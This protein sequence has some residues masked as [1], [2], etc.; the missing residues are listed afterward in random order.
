WTSARTGADGTATV[1]SS[2]VKTGSFAARMSAT[3]NVGSLAYARKTFAPG[4]ND[5]TASGDFNIAAEGLSNS[6]VPIFTLLDRTGADVAKQAF[7]LF[8]DNIVVT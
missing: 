6:N 8:A 2:T 5:F 7:T 4:R 1:Q 3:T